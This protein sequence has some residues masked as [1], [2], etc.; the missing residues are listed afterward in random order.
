[1]P[2]NFATGTSMIQS[3]Y[4]DWGSTSSYG[5]MASPEPNP[6]PGDI[7]GDGSVNVGD[8]LDLIEAWGPCPSP[9]PADINGDGFVNVNDLLTLIAAWGPCT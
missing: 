5:C 4:P 3:Y 9:C 7:N 8:L 2:S 6:C 1:M